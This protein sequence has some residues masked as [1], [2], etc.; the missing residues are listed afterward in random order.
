VSISY[1]RSVSIAAATGSGSPGQPQA[2]T[3]VADNTSEAHKYLVFQVCVVNHHDRKKS[4]GLREY[5]RVDQNGK[6]GR[7][8]IFKDIEASKREGFVNDRGEMVIRTHMRLLS[9]K[10][11]LNMLK[12]AGS[13]YF[14]VIRSA[15]GSSGDDEDGIEHAHDD[16]HRPQKIKIKDVAD[17]EQGEVVRPKPVWV[18]SQRIQV[19][20]YPG[21]HPDHLSGKEGLAVYVLVY[22][23]SLTRKGG[24]SASS[25]ASDGLAPHSLE[26]A[27]QTE[28]PGGDSPLVNHNLLDDPI[29]SHE[30][31]SRDVRASELIFRVDDA[32]YRVGEFV[33]SSTKQCG[34][35]HHRLLVFPKGREKEGLDVFL[36][37]V[38]PDVA[39]QAHPCVAFDISVVNHRD[40]ESTI[41]RVDVKCF[42]KNGDFGWR[43]IFR[44]LESSERK[45]YKN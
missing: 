19:S 7:K 22:V 44:G 34:S 15:K 9:S 42:G 4:I 5:K 18:D 36:E 29:V 2:A 37:R 23:H 12:L 17:F 40:A 16:G 32:K 8:N 25:R 39:G 27:A 26:E 41:T 13:V 24:S 14:L 30:T 20:V 21:G 10:E 28:D 35:F 6:L 3:G 38:S 31:S 45:D 11:V 43:D 33:R 1:L